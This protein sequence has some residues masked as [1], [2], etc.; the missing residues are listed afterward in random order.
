ME[1][2]LVDYRNKE[3]INIEDI[4]G[5]YRIKLT[6]YTEYDGVINDWV[7]RWSPKQA[8]YDFRFDFNIVKDSE[9]WIGSTIQFDIETDESIDDIYQSLLHNSLE[10]GSYAA[11]DTSNSFWHI[12]IEFIECDLED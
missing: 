7:K 2:L 9:K 3:N 1:Y 4:D 8:V 11:H 5:I 10:D 6:F 12:P